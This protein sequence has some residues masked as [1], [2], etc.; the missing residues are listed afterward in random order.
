MTSKEYLEKALETVKNVKNT[1]QD[2]FKNSTREKIKMFFKER[3]CVTLIR[4]VEKEKDLQDLQ[5]L[6]NEDLR[7]TFVE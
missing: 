2:S 3:D 6:L 5:N 4:P 1:E 7:V